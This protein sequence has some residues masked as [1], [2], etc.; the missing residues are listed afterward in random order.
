MMNDLTYADN[1]GAQSKM[2]QFVTANHQSTYRNDPIASS[3]G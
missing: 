1:V 3:Y 2:F